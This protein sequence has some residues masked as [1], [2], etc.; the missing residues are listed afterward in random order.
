M[1]IKYITFIK[2]LL[3]NFGLNDRF[4]NLTAEIISLITSNISI[5]EKV[6]YE[7][8]QGKSYILTKEIKGNNK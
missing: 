1:F 7:K 2:S 8:Y 3:S 6:F 5:P 4:T